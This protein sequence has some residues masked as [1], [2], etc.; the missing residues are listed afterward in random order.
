MVENHPGTLLAFQPEF[1]HG[2]TETWGIENYILTLPSIRQVYNAYMELEDNGAK[3]EFG[4]PLDQHHN[5]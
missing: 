4:L 3:I 2:T 1:L 5:A